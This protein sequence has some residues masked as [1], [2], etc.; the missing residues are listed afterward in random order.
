MPST[1]SKPS[2]EKTRKREL[3]AEFEIIRVALKPED[4]E[5][6]FE[7]I[8]V[9]AKMVLDEWKCDLTPDPFPEWKGREASTLT[10]E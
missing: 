8:G 5:L 1:R 7:G 9:I 6:W 3:E 4:V 2:V 10:S